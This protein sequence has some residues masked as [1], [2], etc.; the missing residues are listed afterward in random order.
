ML[1]V[2]NVLFARFFVIHEQG[3][4]RLLAG[5]G[6]NFAK[7]ERQNKFAAAGCEINLASQRNISVF[8]SLVLPGHLEMLRQIPPAIGYPDISDRAFEPRYGRCQRQRAELSLR[9]Q[10]WPTLVMTDPAVIAVS[11]VAEVRR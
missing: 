3:R 9:E 6:P 1:P 11:A 2:N 4:D 7:A 8:R 5:L 10:H